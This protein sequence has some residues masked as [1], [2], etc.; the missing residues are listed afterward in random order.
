MRKRLVRCFLPKSRVGM[1]DPHVLYNEIAYYVAFGPHGPRTPSSK[2]GD[3]LKI[4]LSS[5]G[6]VGLAGVL[7]AG[8][9]AIGGC[10]YSSRWAADELMCTC[11][12]TSTKD[13]IERMGGGFQPACIGTKNESNYWCVV[14]F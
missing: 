9:R 6:L 7:W 2:P 10:S 4:F 3:N 11:S 1:V 8:I 14:I 13:D 5:M 12:S